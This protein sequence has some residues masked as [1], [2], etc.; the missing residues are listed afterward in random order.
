MKAIQFS[1][2]GSANV[3]EITNAPIPKIQSGQILVQTKAFGINP[4]DW[5]IRNGS[6]KKFIPKYIKPLV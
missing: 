3:L 1:E 2:Y 5:K 6:L 4:V